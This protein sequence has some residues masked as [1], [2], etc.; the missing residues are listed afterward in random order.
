MWRKYA[1]SCASLK[2]SRN[3]LGKHNFL[4]D[5]WKFIQVKRKRGGNFLTFL[6]ENIFIMIVFSGRNQNYDLIKARHI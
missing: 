1:G 6:N 5:L 4:L 2:S 3:L